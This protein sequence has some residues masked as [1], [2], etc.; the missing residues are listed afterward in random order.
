[1]EK[2]MRINWFWIISSYVSLALMGFMDISR[3]PL[4]PDILESL[5]LQEKQ[6]GLHFSFS[7]VAMLLATFL[8]AILLRKVKSIYGLILF[9]SFLM[10]GVFLLSQASGLIALLI[11]GAFIGFGMGGLGV[12]Q[13]L[14]ISEA[15]PVKIQRKFY[16][17]LH[18][19]YA[20]AALFAPVFV[21][22]CRNMGLSWHKIVYICLAPIVIFWL[23]LLVK[24]VIFPS[25][26]IEDD[27]DE[28]YIE[29]LH[30]SKN[31]TAAVKAQFS[32]MIGLYVLSEMV[33]S[34]WMVLFLRKERSIDPI[35]A[36]NYLTLFFV[37]LLLGRLFI[38]FKNLN[39]DNCSLLKIS[40][41]GN[42]CCV[43]MGLSY[44]PLFLSLSGLFMSVF[45]PVAMS[46]LSENFGKYSKQLMP[47]CL[48]AMGLCIS[49]GHYLAGLFA[50]TWGL[51]AS[52]FLCVIGAFFSFIL[53][54]R[55]EKVFISNKKG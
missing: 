48:G 40:L 50:N 15:C 18:S 38:S 30:Y 2:A 53:L 36:N 7:S 25:K 11:A 23:I 6:G 22:Y 33:L 12:C 41:L 10:L 31:N 27:S 14:L 1:M 34:V 3:G 44:H 39:R 21:S 5:N 17:G 13:N 42:L 28:P 55:V 45:F 51:K 32:M 20:A 35:L 46:Y 49:F 8:V 29:M 19:A 37:G 9:L 24:A 26:K 52:L 43:A 54:T 47:L 16:G 4:F